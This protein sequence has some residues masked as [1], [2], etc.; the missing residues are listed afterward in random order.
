MDKM[1]MN[2]NYFKDEVWSHYHFVKKLLYTLTLN[3]LL[4]EDLAQDTMLLCW[5][6]VETVKHYKNLKSAM[7]EIARNEFRQYRRNNREEM[8]ELVDPQKLRWLMGASNIEDFIRKEGDV[9]QFLLLFNG[10]KREY[11]QV[12]LLADY[13]AFSLKDIAK[14]LHKNYNTIISHHTRGLEEMRK[15]R[16]LFEKLVKSNA[17]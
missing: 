13:Y 10:I 16:D 4:T 5:K 7:A 15:K 17:Q 11:V 3:S 2:E 12:V 1:K 14:L 6:K 9:H 8:E